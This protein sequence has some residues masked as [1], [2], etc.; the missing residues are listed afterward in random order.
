G[1]QSIGGQAWWSFG[2]LFLVDSNEQRAMGINES[3]ELAWQDWLGTAGYDRANEDFWGRKWAEKYVQFAYEE[4]R[5]WLRERGVTFCPVVG[6]AV[7]GG[8]LADGHGN[9]VPRFHITWG[10]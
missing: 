2:G 9:S 3:Y 7:R 4:K 5:T 1:E 6:W 8:Y 10:I